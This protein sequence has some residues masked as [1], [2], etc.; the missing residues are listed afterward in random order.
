MWQGSHQVKHKK[1]ALINYT[2]GKAAKISKEAKILKKTLTKTERKAFKKLQQCNN[3]II[4]NADKGNCTVIL[5]KLYYNDE[6]MS[7]LQDPK[8]YHNIKKNL[9]LC[10]KNRLNNFHWKLFKCDKISFLCTNAIWWSGNAFF[11]G[12]RGLRLSCV[13]RGRNDMEMGPAN[14]L[15][16]LA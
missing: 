11:S 10:I 16:A 15:H 3:I 12:A 7:L 6:L 13:A 8:T 2:R 9:I 1:K 4:I 14:S 5:V